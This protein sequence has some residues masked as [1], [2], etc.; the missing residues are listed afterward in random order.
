MSHLWDALKGAAKGCGY[1]LVEHE[2]RDT[3]PDGDE[4]YTLWFRPIRVEVHP[5]D[6]S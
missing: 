5:D 3:D 1:E 6:R 2:Y 4:E